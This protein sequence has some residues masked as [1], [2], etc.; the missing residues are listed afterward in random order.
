MLAARE[1][2]RLTCLDFI[3]SPQSLQAVALTGVPLP[4]HCTVV[5]KSL[6]PFLTRDEFVRLI[7]EKRQPRAVNTITLAVA[8]S[9]LPRPGA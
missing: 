6:L 1:G 5:G 7:P 8:S 4:I 9:V 3:A 2:E